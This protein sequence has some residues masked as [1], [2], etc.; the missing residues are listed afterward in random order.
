MSDA[1]RDAR[2]R[3][4]ANQATMPP[5]GA[6]RSGRRTD[7]P[8]HRRD[9]AQCRWPRP[10]KATSLKQPLPV[11]EFRRGR[12]RPAPG[13]GTLQN[14]LSRTT[15]VHRGP[16]CPPDPRPP[17]LKL[18]RYLLSEFAQSTFA[19]LVVLLIVSV[20]G[21]IT[22]VL[23]DIASG[24]MPA[25]LMLSQLGLVLLNWLPLIL[26]LA[27]MLG[28]MLGVGRLYRDSEMPVIAA[29]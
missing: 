17:M 13:P 14:T 9:V 19:A 29:S 15:P 27:L 1:Q 8:G 26:P 3:K 10:D 4:P 18:D 5:R 21:V 24:R 12:R 23:K 16:S 6:P 2:Q 20:G 28:M 7:P 22:D 11:S 25:G